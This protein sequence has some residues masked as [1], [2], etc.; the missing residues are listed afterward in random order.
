MSRL[1]GK[2]IHTLLETP[3]NA[4]R[5]LKPGGQNTP[6]PDLTMSKVWK[7]FFY[8][9]LPLVCLYKMTSIYGYIQTRPDFFN[10]GKLVDNRCKL[11]S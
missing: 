10:G 7:F 1:L 2:K 8:L 5:T 3:E 6:P 4:L 11:I 9:W